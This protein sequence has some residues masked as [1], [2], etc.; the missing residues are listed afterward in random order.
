MK[1]F[2]VKSLLIFSPFLV[3]IAIE[4]FVLPI[5]FF[6]FRVY[7][8]LRMKCLPGKFYPNMEITKIEEGDSAAHTRFAYK[9][10]VTWITDRYGY[11]KQNTNREKHEIVIIG[12]SHTVGSGLTQEDI[13]SEVLEKRL[14]AGVYPLAPA[15]LST[16]LKDSRFKRHPPDIVILERKE[17]RIPLLPPVKVSAKKTP[18][19][20]E[21]QLG[22]IE[23]RLENWICG[24]RFN[25]VAKVYLDRICKENMLFYLRASLRRLGASPSNNSISTKDGFV[26]FVQGAKVN[27]DVSKDQFD[28]DVTSSRPIM[29]Y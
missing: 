13:L 22:E 8:A 25:Q 14:R 15:S 18:T 26:S 24:N 19:A 9:R 23:D 21:R 17:I 6:T 2:I 12:D 3:A 20:L 29:K 27:E 16:L 7:E 1:K 11:R 28:K 4:V 10:K 5:D